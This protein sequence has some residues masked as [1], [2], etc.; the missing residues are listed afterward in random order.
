[1]DKLEPRELMNKLCRQM[2]EK[3]D[4]LAP[5]RR[6]RTAAAKTVA[7]DVASLFAQTSEFFT[8]AIHVGAHGDFTAMISAKIPNGST[9]DDVHVASIV[10]GPPQLNECPVQLGIVTN[11]DNN[12]L[13]YESLPA[14]KYDVAQRAITEWRHSDQDHTML[15]KLVGRIQDWIDTRKR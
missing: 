6:A 8:S 14:F 2:A 13:K 7:S 11:P 1:M 15:E 5:D 4:A 10:V 3:N 12:T 9:F